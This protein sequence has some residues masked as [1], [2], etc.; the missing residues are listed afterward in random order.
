MWVI[1][2]ALLAL[3][4]GLVNS[5]LADFTASFVSSPGPVESFPAVIVGLP[6]LRSSQL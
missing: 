3:N 4:L 2:S 6:P 1:S 5:N